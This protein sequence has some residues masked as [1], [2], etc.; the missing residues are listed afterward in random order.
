MKQSLFI[1]LM[2]LLCFNGQAADFYGE[3]RGSSWYLEYNKTS[4]TT[5]RCTLHYEAYGYGFSDAPIIDLQDTLKYYKVKSVRTSCFEWADPEYSVT[6]RVNIP[7]SVDTIYGGAF[8]SFRN[9]NN[10]SGY[11]FM[12]FEVHIPSDSQLKYIGDRAFAG[13]DSYHSTSVDFLPSTITYIGSDAFE[14][15]DLP[16]PS[17]GPYYI[18]KY[19]YDYIGSVPDN[20]KV[21]EGTLY[22]CDYVFKGC[23]LYHITFPKSLREIRT[24]AF[25]KSDLVEAI[26]NDSLKYIGDYAFRECSHLREVSLPQSLLSIGNG[27][28]MDCIELERI[29][30]PASVCEIGEKP[31]AY[32]TGEY[33]SQILEYISVDPNNK[34][35]DSRNDCNALIESATNT[36][37][38]GSN[39]TVIPPTVTHIGVYAFSGYAK[40]HIDIPNSVI[41]IGSNA[42]YC[43]KLKHIRIPDSIKS[44]GGFYRCNNLKSIYFGSSVDTIFGFR[45]CGIQSLVLPDNIKYIG[46]SAFEGN[47][48]KTITINRGVDLSASGLFRDIPDSVSIYCYKKPSEDNMEL[49]D[50]TFDKKTM[51]DG[52]LYV[53]CGTELAYRQT[54]G[55]NNFVNIIES[56][57]FKVDINTTTNYGYVSVLEPFECG[58][59]D[60]TIKATPD[61]DCRFVRWT[62]GVTENPRRVT[63]TQDTAFYAEFAPIMYNLTVR[64]NDE[65]MGTVSG[66]GEYKPN[67]EVTIEAHAY[68]GYRFIKW[69]DGI[70]DNPRNITITQ[71]TTFYAEFAPITHKLTVL[72]N[73]EKMGTVSGGGEYK[74]DSTVR[75]EAHANDGF[76]FTRW[77]DN[78][79]ENPRD[80]TLSQDSTFTAYFESIDTK[81]NETSDDGFDVTVQDKTIYVHNSDGNEIQVT[82]ITGRTIYSGYDTTITVRTPGVYIVRCGDQTKK[83][84]VR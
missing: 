22:I 70:T 76:C 73:N 56:L 3:K 75:I 78:I 6:V 49:S 10:V 65:T 63:L 24:E 28:F 11:E 29:F 50:D 48:F 45:K 74:S 59:Y 38:Q 31:F 80:I 44:I 32:T 4:D 57:E 60:Y 68:D 61:E 46:M 64:S 27:A 51:R 82:D 33:G 35:Y 67:S 47:P 13:W 43:S 83:T 1:M 8:K 26:F 52:T 55:W 17:Q 21:A 66:G 7:A 20:F 53:P 23:P 30:I 2:L 37:I 40:E 54:K 34:V 62:D 25:M 5:V 18:G 42:F 69:T 77:N 39:N 71:D 16:A 81:V 14:H 15:A 9:N 19:L 58:V 79:T 84:V 41:S 72:S 12:R 36:I